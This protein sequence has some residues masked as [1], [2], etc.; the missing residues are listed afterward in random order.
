MKKVFLA[1]GLITFLLIGVVSIDTVIANDTDTV[2]CDD[3]PKAD[4]KSKKSCSDFHGKKGK[5]CSSKKSADLGKKEDCKDK[6][7]TKS[8]KTTTDTKDSKKES[9]DKK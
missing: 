5:C 2:V 1:L 6:G 4:K 8:T 9:P 3:P 7:E